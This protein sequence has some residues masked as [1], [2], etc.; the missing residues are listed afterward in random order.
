MT[1]EIH[2]TPLVLVV[3]DFTD[4][5]ELVAELLGCA[6]FRTAEAAT[7]PE[8]LAKAAA[9]RPDLVLL[10]LS[11]PGMDGW[12]IA[13][14]LRADEGGDRVRILALT[15]HSNR[16]PLTDAL[17]AGCDAVLTKPCVPDDLID[18]VR[19]LLADEAPPRR[20]AA[21]R[22]DVTTA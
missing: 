22:E 11:L 14:R 6:G 3:D 8:A 21:D 20:P 12:E 10:D 19:A 5:R 1:A 2:A 15:A 9:L 7:G 13:R 18:R 17:R 4:G 16:K